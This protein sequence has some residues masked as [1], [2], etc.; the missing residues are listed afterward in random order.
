MRWRKKST[1]SCIEVE[2]VDNKVVHPTAL[3][4]RVD[5]FAVHAFNG[6]TIT[7]IPHRDSPTVNLPG[8]PTVE[9]YTPTLPHTDEST[10]P[11]QHTHVD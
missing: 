7:S 6:R 9:R 3:V 8:Q 10:G 11:N 4:G 2:C 1:G 5:G